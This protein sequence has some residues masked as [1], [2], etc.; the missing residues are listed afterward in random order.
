MARIR[1]MRL[2]EMEPRNDVTGVLMDG[3]ACSTRIR[4]GM[5]WLKLGETQWRWN[6]LTQPTFARPPKGATL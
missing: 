6:G 1:A 5:Q 2:D 4:G 3:F